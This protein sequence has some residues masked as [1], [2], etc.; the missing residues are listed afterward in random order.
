ML[1]IKFDNA[2]K[3]SQMEVLGYKFS[4]LNDNFLTVITAY[5]S[6]FLAAEN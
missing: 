4:I 2:P 3:F 6:D 1:K 5:F